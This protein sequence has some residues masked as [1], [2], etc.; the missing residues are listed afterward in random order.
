MCKSCD[1]HHL[2]ER[3]MNLWHDE[4]FDVLIQEAIRC[5][6]SL[7]N[8]CQRPLSGYSQQHLIKVFTRLMLEG[9]VCVL[10]SDG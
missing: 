6:W 5:D 4:Q 3:R 10:L 7:R 9:N 2:L 8:S 1:I